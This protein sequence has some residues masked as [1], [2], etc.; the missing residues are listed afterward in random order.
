MLKFVEK[1]YKNWLID[2]TPRNFKKLEKSI[3]TIKRQNKAWAEYLFSSVDKNLEEVMKGT[4]EE[5]VD[6]FQEMFKSFN[7]NEGRKKGYDKG[8]NE[9]REF[10]RWWD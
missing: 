4:R 7:Y 3:E 9:G 10:Q 2:P 8:W 5:I 1:A 6:A